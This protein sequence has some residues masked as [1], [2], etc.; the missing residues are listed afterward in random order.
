MGDPQGSLPTPAMLGFGDS[1]TRSL[2]PMSWQDIA[3]EFAGD[4]GH[5]SAGDWKHGPGRWSPGVV[6]LQNVRSELLCSRPAGDV[7]GK[8]SDEDSLAWP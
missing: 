8:G 7:E 4:G 3:G 1:V 6:F 2:F 5:L